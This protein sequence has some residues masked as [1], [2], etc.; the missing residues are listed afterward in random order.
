M[1]I[2]DCKQAIDTEYKPLFSQGLLIKHIHE[3]A[4]TSHGFVGFKLFL[5]WSARVGNDRLIADCISGCK[6]AI[7]IGQELAEKEPLALKYIT[8][9]PFPHN[10]TLP[11][12]Y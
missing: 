10:C 5:S 11:E 7:N 9:N 2:S 4:E 12:N 8:G 1:S 3:L 6:K